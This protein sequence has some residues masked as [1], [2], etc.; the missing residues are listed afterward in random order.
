MMVERANFKEAAFFKR[1]AR[2]VEF[3]SSKDFKA[4][5]FSLISSSAS[6][7]SS[8]GGRNLAADLGSREV[9]APIEVALMLAA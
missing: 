3:S 9:G 8:S 2:R 4:A 6:E 5:S 7:A 1:S